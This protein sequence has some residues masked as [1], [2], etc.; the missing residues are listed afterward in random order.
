MSKYLR[1]SDGTLH[2]LTP[3]RFAQMQANG[4]AAGL[5]LFVVD[6]RPVFD[7]ATQMV[8]DG[9]IVVGPVEAHQTWAV[10]AMTAAELERR[11]L[12]A[13]QIDTLIDDV[14]LRLDID[15]AAYNAMLPTQKFDVMRDDR[16]VVLRVARY[17]LRR[18]RRGL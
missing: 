3:E 2:E 18:V 13:E 16:R 11:E 9:G 1:I 6:A 17:L 8:D 15:N 10:R 5:R 14:R 12:Q 4:K 7:A